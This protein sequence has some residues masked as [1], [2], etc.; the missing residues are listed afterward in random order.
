MKRL[1]IPDCWEMAPFES[2]LSEAH[3]EC[4]RYREQIKERKENL[5]DSHEAGYTQKYL[6]HYEYIYRLQ[7]E[8]ECMELYIESITRLKAM[9]N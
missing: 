8:L 5:P 2:L 9:L 6:E 3:K 1:Y 4:D 7:E